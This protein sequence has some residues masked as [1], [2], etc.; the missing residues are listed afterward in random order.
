M[1]A[2]TSILAGIGLAMQVMSMGAQQ[3]AAQE[4]SQALHDQA[5]AQKESEKAKA[6]MA[7]VDAAR[8]RVAQVREERIRRAQVISSAGN[9]GLGMST[10]G[11]AG[12]VSSVGS[13]AG[14][15]IGFINQQETFAGDASKANQ[16]AADASA[17]A[18]VSA[19]EGAQWQTIGALGS[20]VFKDAG[21]FTTIFGGN[22]IKQAGV[23]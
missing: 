22:T 13:Q 2:I 9:Q 16:N 17:R 15:N 18:G 5:A 14:A 6:R 11:V 23:K 1:A 21:G 19:A 4:Q 10:S 7:E 12:S 3:D 8:Q 20:S